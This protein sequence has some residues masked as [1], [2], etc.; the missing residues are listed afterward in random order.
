VPYRIFVAAKPSRR[1]MDSM[2]RPRSKQLR[3]SNGFWS[4]RDL[5]LRFPETSPVMAAPQRPSRFALGTPGSK[6]ISNLSFLNRQT[7]SFDR[8]PMTETP[9]VSRLTSEKKTR[10]LCFGASGLAGA[11]DG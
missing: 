2:V 8:A 10:A 11:G 9:S 4:I 3:F 5:P 1:V 7:I 6:M